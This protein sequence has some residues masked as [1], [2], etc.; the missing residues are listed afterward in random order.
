MVARIIAYLNEGN[1]PHWEP[2][3]L[4][5]NP[6]LHFQDLSENGFIHQPS[7]VSTVI[8]FE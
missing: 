4:Q 8:S 7:L 3:K 1:Y 6:Q 5:A 2:W